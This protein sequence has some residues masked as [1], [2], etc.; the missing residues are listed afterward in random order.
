MVTR[1]YPRRSHFS[2]LEGQRHPEIL[3]RPDYRRSTITAK[4]P[5]STRAGSSGRCQR[6]CPEIG[7]GGL[8]MDAVQIHLVASTAHPGQEG[9]EN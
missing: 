8:E 3:D 2:E 5:L 9:A 1:S 6:I 7:L 4:G